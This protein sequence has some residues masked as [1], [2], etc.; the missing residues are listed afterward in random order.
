MIGFCV[1]RFAHLNDT[2]YSG[3]RT[4]GPAPAS[5]PAPAI[6]HQAVSKERPSPLGKAIQPRLGWRA[7]KR[8]LTLV[9]KGNIMKIHR[10]GL[11]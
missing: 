5:L 8:H 10:R 2:L 7:N 11:P 1:E 6:G 4:V 9:H 3:Q